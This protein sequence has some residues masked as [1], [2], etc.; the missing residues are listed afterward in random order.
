[1]APRVPYEVSDAEALG[2]QGD[3]AKTMTGI[4]NALG[5]NRNKD[6]PSGEFK[7]TPPRFHPRSSVQD[8]IDV[9]QA[10]SG[11]SSSGN[12]V[13]LDVAKH[14]EQ[15]DLR[16]MYSPKQLEDLKSQAATIMPALVSQF[17]TIMA[18]RF[19]RAAAP[20]KDLNQYSASASAERAKTR[21][22]QGPPAD[23]KGRP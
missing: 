20:A 22:L 8:F 16:K 23:W 3:R 19:D 18:K 13:A 1:M 2:W 12:D 10:L 4:A 15:Y 21:T 6:A 7:G 14:P 9:L 11:A 5:G 17:D